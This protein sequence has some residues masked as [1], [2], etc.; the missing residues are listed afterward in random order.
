MPSWPQQC[1]YCG[2][3][4]LHICTHPVYKEPV[5]IPFRAL[6]PL[7]TTEQSVYLCALPY[8]TREHWPTS[9]RRELEISKLQ[10]ITVAQKG[11]ME[12]NLG[13]DSPRGCG[14]TLAG[15][16]SWGFYSIWNSLAQ[17]E[18]SSELPV[19]PWGQSPVLRGPQWPN[20]EL[21]LQ[22]TAYFSSKSWYV[23]M[24]EDAK[25]P[26]KWTGLSCISH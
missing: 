22:V 20:E 2:P 18:K 9:P 11:R 6:I 14:S 24:L 12:M 5:C 21:L 15:V 7:C 26:E 19:A 8:K 23:L 25:L 16:T 17:K 1:I 10:L 13:C 4:T 3:V